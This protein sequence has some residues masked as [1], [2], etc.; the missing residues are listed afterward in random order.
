MTRYREIAVFVDHEDIQQRRLGDVVLVA[1][2][3]QSP[4]QAV[5]GDADSGP[6]V[7]ELAGC[8]LL[9]RAFEQVD[10]IGIDRFWGEVSDGSSV[11]QGVDD[12]IGAVFV[13][14]VGLQRFARIRATRSRSADTDAM[15]YGD[16][17]ALSLRAR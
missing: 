9:G 3:R 16:R 2:I 11:E 17:Q 8:G 14:S 13:H 1:D 4:L 10:D 6:V 5:I 15:A 7:E 12:R